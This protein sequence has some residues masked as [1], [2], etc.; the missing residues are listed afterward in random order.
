MAKDQNEWRPQ[1]IYECVCGEPAFVRISFD[2]KDKDWTLIFEMV[3]SPG[4]RY[5]SWRLRQAVN[6]VLG[7][8]ISFIDIILGRN[9]AKKFFAQMAEWGKDLPQH[10]P[11]QA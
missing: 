7:R 3:P 4:R 10:S 5:F 11:K 9:Q 1:A 2:S 8:G 6:L